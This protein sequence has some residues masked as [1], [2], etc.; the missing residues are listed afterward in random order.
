MSLA[1]NTTA[2]GLHCR[3]GDTPS[4]AAIKAAVCWTFGVAPIDMVSARRSRNAA[5][6]RQIA[7]FLARELTPFSLPHIGRMFGDRDHTTVIHACRKVELLIGED[8]E[9]AHKIIT[10]RDAVV[11][12]STT[13]LGKGATSEQLLEA[14]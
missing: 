3:R 4:V 13:Q 2:V 8:V 12:I 14:A 6:P 7:M 9:L 10:I 11:S 5:R 1:K